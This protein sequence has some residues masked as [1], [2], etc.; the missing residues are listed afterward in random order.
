MSNDGGAKPARS[1]TARLEGSRA[2]SVRTANSGRSHEVVGEQ[3]ASSGRL[4]GG[5]DDDPAW[6]HLQ[7]HPAADGLYGVA[8][9]DAAPTLMGRFGSGGEAPNFARAFTIIDTYGER[10]VTLLAVAKRAAELPLHLGHSASGSGAVGRGGASGHVGR[11]LLKRSLSH[12]APA[13]AAGRHRCRPWERS[14]RASLSAGVSS[15]GVPAVKRHSSEDP[16]AASSAAL[17]RA[18]SPRG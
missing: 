11:S 9:V 6:H 18:V 14:P 13:R 10:I 5:R 4:P 17:A 15:T 7:A 8:I 16:R 1:R 12:P 3:P 2:G